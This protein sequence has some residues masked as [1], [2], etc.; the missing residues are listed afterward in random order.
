MLLALTITPAIV[1]LAANYLPRA[2]EVAVDW[3]VL[4]FALGAAGVAS[5]LSSLAPLRQ[6][7][8][9]A[10]IE[11]LTEGVRA[12]AGRRSRRGSQALVVAEIALAFS[13][14]A[15]SAVLLAH[16]RNL[17]RVSAWLRR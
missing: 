14:L 13:L 3:T 6:A 12:S 9:T 8:R 10:P 5:V 4:L 16:L 7:V 1:S 17:S 15:V 11:V 2:E